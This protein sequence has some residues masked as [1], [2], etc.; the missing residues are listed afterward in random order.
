MRHIVKHE[1]SDFYGI[2]NFYYDNIDFTSGLGMCIDEPKLLAILRE[3]NFEI[4][5]TDEEFCFEDFTDEVGIKHRKLVKLKQETKFKKKK[6]EANAH[7]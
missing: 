5:G 3:S 1:V 7:V 4:I 2:E 6:V